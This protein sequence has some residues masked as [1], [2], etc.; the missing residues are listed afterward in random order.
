MENF[1]FK[2]QNDNLKRWTKLAIECNSINSNC[3]ICDFVPKHLKYIC[4]VKYYIPFLY[5]KLGNPK[6][7]G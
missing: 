4:K 1:K 7:R 6:K 3:L 5:K 2:P